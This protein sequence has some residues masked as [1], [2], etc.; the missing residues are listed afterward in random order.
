MALSFR[1]EICVCTSVYSGHISD[2][3]DYRNVELCFKELPNLYLET[4]H[5]I[6]CLDFIALL[7]VVSWYDHIVIFFSHNNLFTLF[8][9]R[10]FSQ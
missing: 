7:N 5:C 4:W 2:Y 6:S 1:T 10:I 3:T 8:K 9:K